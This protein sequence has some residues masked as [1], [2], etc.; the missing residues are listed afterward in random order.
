MRL[1]GID[2]QGEDPFGAAAFQRVDREQNPHFFC[3][4]PH[5]NFV[6]RPFAAYA[7]R[8]WSAS[9]QQRIHLRNPVLGHG[10]SIFLTACG[11]ENFQYGQQLVVARRPAAA[12]AKSAITSQFSA[13]CCCLYLG[14]TGGTVYSPVENKS[15]PGSQKRHCRNRRCSMLISIAETG[16]RTFSGQS[17]KRSAKCSQRSAKFSISAMLHC[18]QKFTLYPNG[19]M[20]CIMQLVRLSGR[21]SSPAICVLYQN[22]LHQFGSAVVD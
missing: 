11:S 10:H 13:L 16:I 4:R 8:V 2:Q 7:G 12:H 15:V 14:K 1:D 5:R 17:S 22:R 21:C 20:N 9:L 19:I 3:R 18:S 6:L